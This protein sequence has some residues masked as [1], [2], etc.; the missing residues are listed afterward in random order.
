MVYRKPGLV[1]VSAKTAQ[2]STSRYRMMVKTDSFCLIICILEQV[3]V[4]DI[5]NE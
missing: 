1:T 5:E 2:F 4:E 3:K